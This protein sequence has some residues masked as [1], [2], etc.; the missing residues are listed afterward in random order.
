MTHTLRILALSLI[1]AAIVSGSAARANEVQSVERGTGF[2]IHDASETLAQY[3][4]WDG[5]KLYFAM[6]GG[7]RTE[8]IT[9]TSDAAI[10]NPGDG[11]FH[12]YDA[13]QVRAALDA[14]RFPLAHVSAEI[15]ILPYPRR[16]GLESA[17]G[18]GLI[19]LSPGVRALPVELQHSEFTHEL[20]HVVQYAL[21]PDANKADWARYRSLRGIAD[22]QR[23]TA[24]SEH[25]NR[26]HEIFA[27]DFR[28]LFGDAQANYTGSIENSEIARPA[29]VNG[30]ADMMT[31]LAAAPVA[32]TALKVV[33][34]MPH[35]SVMLARN[36]AGL[37]T[38]DVFD[39][40]GR[41]VASVEPTADAMGCHWEWD[42]RAT[43]GQHVQ[44]T[45]LFARA[46]DG[47]GGAA[48]I[49]RLP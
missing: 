9:S 42:G 12:P 24:T 14:V 46:R 41:K 10:A 1:T 49:V 48:K 30:L 16:E 26:P 29:A 21:L 36:G 4:T 37:A 8:L 15:F 28:A 11:R 32:A 22:E 39:V 34:S 5:G 13:A 17:A 25:A 35:G 45:V 38:L 33:S 2:T 19:L 40:M 23:Y 6:P 44:P 27:E 31:A 7:E 20:G 43:T 47:R 3:C 18:P